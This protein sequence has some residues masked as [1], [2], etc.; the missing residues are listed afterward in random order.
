MNDIMNCKE[1]GCDG[2]IDQT[3]EYSL[4]IG[5]SDIAPALPCSNCGRFHW[6]ADGSLVFS[7]SDKK[8]FLENNRVIYRDRNSQ[9]VRC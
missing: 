8:A 3:N 2:K 5:C 9:L 4:Q 7:R 6:K 1:E